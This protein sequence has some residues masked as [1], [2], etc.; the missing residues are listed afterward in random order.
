MLQQ[1]VVDAELGLA[2]KGARGLGALLV[3]DDVDEGALAGTQRLLAQRPRHQLAVLD[4]HLQECPDVE[5]SA[6]S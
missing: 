1:P 5:A 4:Q 3:P 6:L 2:Q